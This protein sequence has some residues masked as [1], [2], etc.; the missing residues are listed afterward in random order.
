MKKIYLT[1]G[2]MILLIAFVSASDTSY[3]FKQNDDVN[4]K[5]RCFAEDG[6]CGSGTVCMLSIDAPNGT[7]VMNNISMTYNETFLNISLPTSNLGVYSAVGI[8]LSQTNA[9]SEFTY[10]VTPSG[11]TAPNVGESM[12]YIVTI[13]V[14]LLFSIIFFAISLTFKKDEKGDYPSHGAGFKFGL[15]G[16]SLTIALI[17]LLYTTITIQEI[18]WGFDKITSSF[19]TFHYLILFIFLVIF[20]FILVVI[21]MQIMEKMQ[22]KRGLKIQ[23]PVGKG[24]GMP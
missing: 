20:I 12:V 16:L 13:I 2:V 15:I 23:N 24:Q 21:I 22:L 18:F 14:M 17:T 4:L 8:C 3:V 19:S 6:Y 5:M 11:R 10:L 9:T 7:N 1:L